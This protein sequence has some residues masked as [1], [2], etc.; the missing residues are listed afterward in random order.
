M[1]I[2][3]G[4]RDTKCLTYGFGLDNSLSRAA[5]R[6]NILLLIAAIATFASWLASL[7]IRQAG[8]ASDYQAHSA[9]HKGILS[10]VFLGREALKRPLELLQKQFD[11]LWKNLFALATAQ[12]VMAF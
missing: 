8:K 7:H 10:S 9:K 4:F 11:S 3:E 12:T 1:Q 2:E 5:V 6:M